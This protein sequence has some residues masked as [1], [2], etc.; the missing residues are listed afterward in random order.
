MIFLKFK[1]GGNIS[2][3]EIFRSVFESK[4]ILNKF[5]SLRIIV[6]RAITC[7]RCIIGK[8]GKEIISLI[9]SFDN[10]MPSSDFRAMNWSVKNSHLFTKTIKTCL[11]TSR[12]SP[13]SNNV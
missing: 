6:I 11:E 10:A 2:N 13:I 8:S 5:K 3:I 7:K 9:Y 1:D 4:R 12:M